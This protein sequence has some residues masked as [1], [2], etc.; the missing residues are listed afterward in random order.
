MTKYANYKDFNLRKNL[1][2][3]QKNIF[4]L[5]SFL[6]NQKNSKKIR[7]KI[8]LK[9]DRTYNTLLGNKIKNRCI[10]STK[11]RSV[12][13]VTNLT[14]SSFRDNLRWGKVTGFR[15]SSW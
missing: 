13:R 10:Y 4:L 9:M 15:K 14:K 3:N 6:L 5:K 12:Y 11:I 8:M 7:F 2:K 1:E